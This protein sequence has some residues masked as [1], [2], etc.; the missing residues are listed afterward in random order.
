MLLLGLGTKDAVIAALVYLIA[1]ACYKGALFLIA[2]TLEHE[3]GSRNVLDLGGLGRSMPITALAGVLAACSM[4]G[5][6]LSLGFVAKELLYDTLLHLGGWA[7]ALLLVAIVASALLG[8]AGFIAGFSPFAGAAGT[9][10]AKHAVPLGLAVPP[11]L[12]AVVGFAAGLWPKAG[13]PTVSLAASSVLN[14]VPCS[15]L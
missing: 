12:L 15:V 8:S 2:G 1:H 7:L 11:F 3:T 5:I 13:S 9:A 4:A 6:P 10:A 14:A